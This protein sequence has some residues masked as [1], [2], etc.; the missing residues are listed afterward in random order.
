M[1]FQGA[2]KVAK[3]LKGLL[4]PGLQDDDGEEIPPAAAAQ[5]QQMKQQAEQ[6]KQALQQMRQALVEAEGKAKQAE[7]DKSIE[8]YR[9]QTE[10]M[11][12][13]ADV[14][15][16]SQQPVDNDLAKR[17]FEAQQKQLDR[18]HDMNKHI[19]T[20]AS[21]GN[22]PD[23]PDVMQEI[24]PAMEQIAS[25]LSMLNAPRRVMRDEAGNII[26]SEAIS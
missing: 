14:A 3:M 4:P 10:R 20:V 23:A 25:A 17:Q 15:A 1:D 26:G 19:L 21:A 13:E 8:T 2:D 6:A 24:A 12:V 9:A 5:M 7:T 22:A 11:K 18:E 16:K